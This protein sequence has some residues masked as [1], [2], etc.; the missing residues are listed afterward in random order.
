MASKIYNMHYM[1][2][3]LLSYFLQVLYNTRKFPTKDHYFANHILFYTVYSIREW[4]L[5]TSNY[6]RKELVM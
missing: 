1:H 4:K 3:I 2:L 5:N 6:P